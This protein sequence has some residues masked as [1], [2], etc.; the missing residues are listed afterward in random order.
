MSAVPRSKESEFGKWSMQPGGCRR[1]FHSA[2]RFADHHWE[3]RAIVES[4]RCRLTPLM[5]SAPG[6][7]I[8]DDNTSLRMKV[9]NCNE[10][11]HKE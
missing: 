7:P 4:F 1:P 11:S 3:E 2:Q 6:L 10:L 8:C 9:R 5:W